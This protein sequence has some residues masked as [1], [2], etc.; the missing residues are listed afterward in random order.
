M[1]EKK[2]VPKI[3][4]IHKQ[5]PDDHLECPPPDGQ[6]IGKSGFGKAFESSQSE[7]TFSYQ[8]LEKS[9]FLKQRFVEKFLS[10]I[11]LKI[12]NFVGEK[13]WNID[14]SLMFHLITRVSRIFLCQALLFI[15]VRA[16]KIRPYS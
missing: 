3:H 15:N 6:T 10:P 11:G 9:V 2:G 12:S 1:L 8:H 5:Y 4:T 16:R 7:G 14:D 13:W